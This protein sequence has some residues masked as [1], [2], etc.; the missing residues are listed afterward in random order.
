MSR[1]GNNGT[2]YFEPGDVL[3]GGLGLTLNAGQMPQYPFENTTIT[4]RVSYRSKGGRVW[5]YENYNLDSFTFRWVMLDEDKKEQLRF[6]YDCMP[7]LAF[8]SNGQDF[9]TF[10]IVDSSWKDEEVAYELYDLSF[11]VEEVG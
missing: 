2:F 10:R 8:T 9:G 3:T 6:M 7:I 4:D 1:F 11:T 5:Q